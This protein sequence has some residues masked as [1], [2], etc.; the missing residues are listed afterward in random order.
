MVEARPKSARACPKYF[1]IGAIVYPCDVDPSSEG[2]AW[3][4]LG[5]R[6]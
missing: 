2:L 5:V 4:G 6:V 1:K 3:V